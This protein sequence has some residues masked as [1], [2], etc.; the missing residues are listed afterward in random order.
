M[1]VFII[2]QYTL[3]RHIDYSS[4]NLGDLLFIW[5]FFFFLLRNLAFYPYSVK[6]MKSECLDSLFKKMTVEELNER[7]T[8]YINLLFKKIKKMSTLDPW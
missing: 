2:F 7:L 1:S 4:V 5:F 6:Q 3:S 8:F